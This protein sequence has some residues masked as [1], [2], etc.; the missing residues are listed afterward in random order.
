MCLRKER[1]G[2][3]IV[4]RLYIG[5]ILNLVETKEV[6]VEDKSHVILTN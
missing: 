6:T 5:V 4:V 3:I 1:R 2:V